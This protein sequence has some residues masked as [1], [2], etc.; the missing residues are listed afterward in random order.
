MILSWLTR[1]QDDHLLLPMTSSDAATASTIHGEA[2]RRAWSDGE[3]SSLLLQPAVF[4]FLA[5]EP[6]K[7]R[8]RASG[9]VLAREAAGEA[10]ILTIGVLPRARRMAL[11]WRL[12]R[13]A[14]AE[15]GSRGAEEM[16]LEVDETNSAAI[17]L[18]TKLKFI[19]AGERK[20]YYAHP[21]E[22]AT[23]ALVMRLDLR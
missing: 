9:F 2:F 4:G 15:A 11:G 12:M 14:I 23:A 17:A 6:G 19:K 7:A 3:F 5:C 22:A 8:T 16:F 13:A 1:R 18:Y 10:E 21:G 20:A